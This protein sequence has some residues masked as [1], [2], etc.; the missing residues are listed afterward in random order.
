MKC[1]LSIIVTYL[2]LISSSFAQNA[3]ILTDNSD[4]YKLAPYIKIFEDKSSLLEIEDIIKKNF[5]KNFSQNTDPVPNF[6]YS[7]S[8]IWVKFK[9][10]KFGV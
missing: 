4:S 7:N 3:I 2:L 1:K 8:N 6:G 5:D 9:V 10:K